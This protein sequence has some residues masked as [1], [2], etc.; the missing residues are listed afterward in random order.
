MYIENMYITFSCLQIMYVNPTAGNPSGTSLPTE[1][2][3]EI[4][5]LACEYN[6]LILEDDPYF[7]LQFNGVSRKYVQNTEI[8]NI[9][10]L[11]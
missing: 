10:L 2:K 11:L 4:Y 3:I 5:R 9:S 1:R 8:S 6:F 7:F